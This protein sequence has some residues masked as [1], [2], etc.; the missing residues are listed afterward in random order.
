M[1][2][3]PAI[4]TLAAASLACVSIVSSVTS[5]AKTEAST[6]TSPSGNITAT[7]G[8]HQGRPF[9][10]V[11]HHDTAVV[12]TSY[13]GL[14][15]TH[16]AIGQDAVIESVTPTAANDTWEQTWGEDRVVSNH[17]NGAIIALREA[18]GMAYE[19]EMRVFDDG[20]G[21][22]YRVPTQEGVDSLTITDELTQFCLHDDGKVWS[23]PWDH[24]YYEALWR[25]SLISRLDT[26]CSPITVKMTDHL[27]LTIHEA[28]LTD[29]ASMNLTHA[30]DGA[31]TCLTTYL[32]PW[33]TG[34][35]V[36]T[37]APFTTPWRTIIIGESA[38]DLMLS[39]L[40]LNLNEPCAIEDV[41][42][43]EP[44]RYIGIWWGMHMKDYTWEMEHSSKHGAT[45]A[46]T[47][48]YI[49]FAAQNGF[50]GVLVEGWNKTWYGDW[51]KDGSQFDFCTPYPD[52]DLTGLADYARAKGV[53]LIAHNETGGAATNYEQ[54]M[55]SAFALYHS[56]GINSIKTGYVNRLLDGKE[57]H[58]SQYGVRHYRR[59]IET[60]AKNQ[61]MIDNHE[62][63]MPTGLQRTYP[64]LMTQEGVRGCE[65]E[66]W[67]PDGGNPPEHVVTLPFTRGLAGPMDYTPGIF[68]Y[69]NKLLPNTHPHATIAKQLAMTLILYSPLQMAADMI[70]N[71]EGHPEF[72]FLTRCPTTWERTVVPEAEIGEYVT[73]ARKVRDGDDWYLGSMSGKNCHTADIALDFLD[74]DATYTARIFADGELADGETNPYPV[75]IT[76]QQVDASSTLHLA[77]ARS[78]GATAILTKNP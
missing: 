71:Y 64:N 22:R 27:Y 67:S 48:R 50:G 49:D 69:N 29:Y 60:A 75:D 32:T 39:R 58:G 9:Y 70:E 11:R 45:T 63:V 57:L 2:T 54:Q 47:K 26:V 28:A 66:A 42:W 6:L 17:Y 23:I 34:E 68:N 16:G 14:T 53:R 78:G 38:A 30:A 33:S 41:S 4:I 44:Q 40:M 18:S 72:E 37:A 13:L 3:L 5:C 8:T 20:V 62:P 55:D 35:K 19:V 76:E 52:Y 1:K 65:Y 59:V 56:L 73:V 21:L 10:T 25:P 43:I 61:I 31:P 74:P 15:F 46:N 36:F 51:S 7:F 77:L 24:E 12:D